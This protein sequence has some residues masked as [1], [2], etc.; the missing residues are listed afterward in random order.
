MPP[1]TKVALVL[2]GSKMNLEEVRKEDEVK[3][4]EDV[5]SARRG[6]H[7]TGGNPG[8]GEEHGRRVVLPCLG[9]LPHTSLR[10]FSRAHHLSIYTG[11]C[12]SD[13]ER[14]L[15]CAKVEAVMCSFL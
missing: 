3:M 4:A 7:G 15:P 5:T 12:E 13:P 1:T 11:R 8:E 9:G 2:L 14:P 6:V 10:L